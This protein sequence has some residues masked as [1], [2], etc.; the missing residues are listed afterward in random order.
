MRQFTKTK[1]DRIVF[2]TEEL[3]QQLKSRLDYKHRTR[4]LVLVLSLGVGR[5]VRIT[6]LN[7]SCPPLHLQS[8]QIL[9]A[10]IS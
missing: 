1:V 7:A 10:R 5:A 8:N 6:K 4:V 9:V 3:T 2:L